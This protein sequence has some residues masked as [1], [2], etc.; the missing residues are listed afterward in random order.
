M[1]VARTPDTERGLQCCNMREVATDIVNTSEEL[2]KL[3]FAGGCGEIGNMCD[4]FFSWCNL[5]SFDCMSQDFDIV[6]QEVV[7]I[8][9]KKEV[10]F[11]EFF[12]YLPKM[13]QVMIVRV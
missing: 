5:I 13:A 6:N 12:V 3:P 4:F 1:A 2:L 7:F 11:L 8:H 10:I 9:P